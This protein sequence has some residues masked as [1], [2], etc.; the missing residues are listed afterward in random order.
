MTVWALRNKN[1]VAGVSNLAKKGDYM[2]GSEE[3]STSDE[4]KQKP[5]APSFGPML[6]NVRETLNVSQ[7]EL[8]ARLSAAGYEIDPTSLNKYEK[9]TRRPSAGFIP[10]FAH[11]LHLSEDDEEDIFK[12]YVKDFWLAAREDYLEEKQRLLRKGQ[13]GI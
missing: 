1:A 4:D 9:G 8:Q 2:S 6:R 5:E 12:V 3:R 13:G 10:W 7:A 11:V